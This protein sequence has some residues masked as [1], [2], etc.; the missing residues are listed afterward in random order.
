MVKQRLRR[1]I[2]LRLVGLGCFTG[3]GVLRVMLTG[4]NAQSRRRLAVFLK[5]PVANVKLWF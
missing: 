3:S 1:F 4:V 5:L 2:R